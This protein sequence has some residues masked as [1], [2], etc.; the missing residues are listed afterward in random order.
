MSNNYFG[1]RCDK[2]G[3]FMAKKL[4]YTEFATKERVKFFV[5][6]GCGET[7]TVITNV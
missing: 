7:K 5:C 3:K 2:C 1:P 6:V 4:D